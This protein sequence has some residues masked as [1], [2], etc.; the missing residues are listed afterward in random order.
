MEK[1]LPWGLI[2]M[3]K[4]AMDA[5]VL[6]FLSVALLTFAYIGFSYIRFDT[7]PGE[8]GDLHTAIIKNQNELN[9]GAYVFEQNGK[10]ALLSSLGPDQDQEKQAV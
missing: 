1:L 4:K 2:S 10:S 3:N 7:Y 8:I 9:S 6:L 5:M